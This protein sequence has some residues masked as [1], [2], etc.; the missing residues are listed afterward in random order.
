ML[1]SKFWLCIDTLRLWLDSKFF[2]NVAAVSWLFCNSVFNL[3]FSVFSCVVSPYS[4]SFSLN[5][6]LFWA[7]AFLSRSSFFWLELLSSVITLSFCA[8]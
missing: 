3:A 8:S 7:C 1:F 5:S 4:F 2:L 6:C